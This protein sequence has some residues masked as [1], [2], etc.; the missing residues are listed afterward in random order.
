M[1]PGVSSIFVFSDLPIMHYGRSP[2]GAVVPGPLHHQCPA[3]F[4]LVTHPKTIGHLK[5]VPVPKGR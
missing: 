4:P 3:V 1:Q 2:I 5:A